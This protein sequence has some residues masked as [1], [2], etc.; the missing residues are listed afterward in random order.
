M[1]SE[2]CT[3]VKQTGQ[4]EELLIINPLWMILRNSNSRQIP[5]G[6]ILSKGCLGDSFL[7]KKKKKKDFLIVDN[8]C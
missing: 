4:Y 1:K 3:Q 8:Y 2:S 7:A 6:I 5:G